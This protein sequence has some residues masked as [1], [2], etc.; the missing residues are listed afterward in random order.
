MKIRERIVLH[1][2]SFDLYNIIMIS[3]SALLFK[4]AMY[5]S[6]SP[7]TNSA[8]CGYM[9]V[10]S[11][12]RNYITGSRTIDGFSSTAISAFTESKYID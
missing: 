12:S 10:F 4:N 7:P 8:Q 1:L 6:V 2:R 5:K 3:I 11:T 9:K